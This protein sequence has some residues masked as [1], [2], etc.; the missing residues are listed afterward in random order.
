MFPPASIPPVPS[1]PQGVRRP[2]FL[3]RTG[4]FI[5]FAIT[6]ISGIALGG[7]YEVT[8]GPI[9]QATIEANNKTYRGVF[10]EASSFEETSDIDLEACNTELAASD[11]GGVGVETVM[12][13]KDD[14]GSDLG[15]VINSYSNDS[16]GGKVSIS[17]GIKDD[18]SITSIGF[19]EISDTPGLGL[20]AK[21]DPFRTQYDGKSA[22][23]LT[24]V[25]GGNAGDAEINAISGATITS[26]AV[27]NAV[28]A[29]LYCKQNFIN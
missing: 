20:K 2:G 1:F 24:V 27:T 9:E 7:V 21:E 28:N 23:E 19:R 18:G 8:K 13:A 6:L 16:Y 4:F 14:A 5:L 26:N 17:V 25:K 29:A 10:P 3:F 22:S 11:F 15:Y 12:V